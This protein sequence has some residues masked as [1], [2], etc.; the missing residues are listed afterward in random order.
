MADAVNRIVPSSVALDRASWQGRERQKRKAKEPANSTQP[1]D[2]LA[3]VDAMDGAESA[4]K[5][6]Q[7]DKGKYLDISV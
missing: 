2:E 7:K 1:L 4:P 3:P 5:E 6:S